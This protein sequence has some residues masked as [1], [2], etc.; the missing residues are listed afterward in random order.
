MWSASWG[1]RNNDCHDQVEQYSRSVRNRKQHKPET[2]QSWIHTQVLGD[3]FTHASHDS[4]LIGPVKPSGLGRFRSQPVSRRK[5]ETKQ[6]KR[7]GVRFHDLSLRRFTA[8]N[9][10]SG[11]GLGATADNRENSLTQSHP[12]HGLVSTVNG[13]RKASESPPRNVAHSSRGNASADKD[14]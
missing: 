6:L 4:V 9:W 13:D 5:K 10:A 3:S 8:S 11:R 12:K 7:V 1:P 14:A 2:D